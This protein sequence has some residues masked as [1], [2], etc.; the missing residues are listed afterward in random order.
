M[1]TVLLPICGLLCLIFRQQLEEMA[2]KFHFASVEKFATE[3]LKSTSNQRLSWL[4]QYYTSVDYPDLASTVSKHF[5]QAIPAKTV[6]STSSNASPASAARFE[7]ATR[8]VVKASPKQKRDKRTKHQE[9]KLQVQDKKQKR[10]LF[11]E[12]PSPE[13]DWPEEKV[14]ITSGF[15]KSK[16]SAKNITFA[17]DQKDEDGFDL[18]SFDSTVLSNNHSEIIP[19]VSVA[20]PKPKF[21]E[22]SK[23]QTSSKNSQEPK[24]NT[25]ASTCTNPK[26]FLTDLI[27][28]TSILS[29]LFKPKRTSPKI[30]NSSSLLTCQNLPST[31][32]ISTD[33]LLSSKPTIAAI[34]EV[35][36]PKATIKK[37]SK[38]FW[39][40]LQE[41]DE[42]S[43]N[44]LTDPAEVQRV[45]VNT[46]IAAREHYKQ[47]EH[48][49]L[50][51]TNENFLWKK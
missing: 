27:G 40:V 32:K 4:H 21:R 8:T 41:G 45:C 37:A 42:E 36:P 44:R 12:I 33:S 39:D 14:E 20:L 2:E 18:T 16:R 11:E 15:K 49:S 47:E 38:D 24:M 31:S 51:K 48:K 34:C 22:I 35:S 30:S 23:E 9:E 5:P 13:A 46:N 26:S 50:W 28:D 19:Q 25:D 43:L 17:K 3:I 29:D 1:P 7:E 10:H 6:P